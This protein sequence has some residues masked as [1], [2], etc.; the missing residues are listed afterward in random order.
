MKSTVRTLSIN[1]LL[2]L[3]LLMTTAGCANAAHSSDYE[4]QTGQT[5]SGSLYIASGN[6]TLDQG[7][8]VQGSVYMLCCNL[9]VRGEVDGNIDML[10]GNIQ[11]D[12]QATIRGTV[13]DF[14]GDQGPSGSLSPSVASLALLRI[15]AS[16]S[17]RLNRRP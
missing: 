12:P 6:V 14:A 10:T 8:R 9:I 7:S 2:G 3:A 11:V 16:R 17:S 1:M 5:V 4:L 13:T 15:F